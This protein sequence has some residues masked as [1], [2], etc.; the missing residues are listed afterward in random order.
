MQTVSSITFATGELPNGGGN[1]QRGGGR[2]AHARRRCWRSTSRAAARPRSPALGPHDAI[3][4][5]NFAREQATSSVGDTLRRAH[6]DSSA[7]RRFRVLG[8]GEGRA[9]PARE[10]DHRRERAR[11][12]SAASSPASRSR[13]LAPG[14]VAEAACRTAME[15]ALKDRLPDGRGAEP[16]PAEGPAGAAG[17]PAARAVYALLS[18]ARDR[19]AVRDREHAGAVDP[20]AHARARHAARGRHVAPP[21]AADGPLRG[22]DHRADRRDPRH[23]A[24]RASSRRSCR[25]RSPTRASSSRIRSAR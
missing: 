20:R 16:E 18:L 6:A 15:D 10:G 4:D 13:R 5:D 7:P 8:H 23:G 14:R 22:R 25:G 24:G 11:A 17:Q 3:V 12:S 9:R 2:P 21:G 19:V 1:I